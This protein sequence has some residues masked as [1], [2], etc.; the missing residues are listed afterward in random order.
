MTTSL[1]SVLVSA[2]TQ[3]ELTLTEHQIKQLIDYTLELEKWNKTYNLTAIKGTE[4]LLKRHVIDA[5]SVVDEVK[6]HNPQT[7]ADIGTGGGI[8]G[9]ILAIVFPTL[10]IYLV[11]SIGKKCRFLRH[12]VTQL[13]LSTNVTIVQERVE[14]WQPESPISVIICRAFTN[15]ANFTTIT[16]HLGNA[17]SMWMAMKSAYTAEEEQQL[18]THFHLVDNLTLNVPFEE[19]KRQLILLTKMQ[20]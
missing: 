15:L 18:P 14:A 6:R 3:L 13:G 2:L 10:D 9:I 7:L 12:I 16:Q 5:L 20:G 11:E 8:P 19:A 17:D 4:N 1:H